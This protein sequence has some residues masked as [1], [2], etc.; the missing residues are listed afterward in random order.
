MNIALILAGGTGTRLGA[1]IP[2]Q[3]IDVG[4]KPI[5]SYC[6]ERF[7]EHPQVDAIQVVAETSWYDFIQ[8]QM[9][10]KREKFR[11]F[12][13]PGENRQL[14]ILNGL[15]DIDR[16]AKAEDVVIIHDAARPCVSAQLLSRGLAL[17]REREGVMP[18]L[19]MK[20]TVY[21]SEDGEKI[22]SLLSREKIFAGQ[23]P[24]FFRFGRYKA[25]NQVLV[26]EEICCIS[27]STEPAILYGMDMGIIPGEEANFKITTSQDLQRF[28]QMMEE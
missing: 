19:P 20:D 17:M 3:Y 21:Y 6:L 5:I 26:P 9:P 1:S 4:G 16:Y 15:M 8:K 24:E 27:G 12:S 28:R 23:A 2:K 13:L 14:S 7:F 11:G 10:E 18:V 25:A 22:S